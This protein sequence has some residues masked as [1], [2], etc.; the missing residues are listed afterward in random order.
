MHEGDG[1]GAASK[2]GLEDALASMGQ[3]TMSLGMV[4]GP[5]LGG[6][7]LDL[8]PPTRDPGC[9][10]AADLWN[11]TASDNLRRRSRALLATA[12]NSSSSSSSSSSTGFEGPDAVD[13]CTSGFAWTTLV[14]AAGFLALFAAAFSLPNRPG[15]SSPALLRGDAGEEPSG[16]GGDTSPRFSPLCQGAEGTSATGDGGCSSS[17]GGGGGPRGSGEESEAHR[18]E[19]TGATANGTKT[20]PEWRGAAK[21]EP[22][23]AGF[24][25]S[26]MELGV[27]VEF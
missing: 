1:D 25:P 27:G 23:P 15:R 5:L 9:G 16:D 2:D 21:R 13:E 20:Q 18:T 3:A 11:H 14:F 4:L 12:N 10:A 19:A 6:L 8:L 26:Y 22:A 7:G 17:S 24:A